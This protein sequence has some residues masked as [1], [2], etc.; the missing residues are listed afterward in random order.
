MN[1][2]PLLIGLLVLTLALGSSWLSR[3]SEEG[4]GPNPEAAAALPDYFIKGLTLTAMGADGQPQYRLHAAALT[5][6]PDDG[7]TELQAPHFELVATAG[8][9][10]Q[11]EAGRGWMPADRSEIRFADGVRIRRTDDTADGLTIQTERLALWPARAHA[12]TDAP[13]RIESS[14]TLLTADGLQLDLTRRYLTLDANIRGRY[15]PK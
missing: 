1:R 13:I 4:A 14:D 12:A 7:R 2:G 11:V 8:P 9:A 5:H 10:W 3:R 6:Y 15:E